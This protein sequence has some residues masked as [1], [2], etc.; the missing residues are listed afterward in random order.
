MPQRNTRRSRTFWGKKKNKTQKGK[1][2]LL[3]YQRYLVEKKTK[4]GPPWQD[5]HGAC[6]RCWSRSHGRVVCL[7][8]THLMLP[9]QR[10]RGTA[11][12]LWAPCKRRIPMPASHCFKPCHT[13]TQKA[14]ALP[15]SPPQECYQ[16]W[17]ACVSSKPS[18]TAQW[19]VPLIVGLVF[20]CAAFALAVRGLEGRSRTSAHRRTPQTE[21]SG[22][23]SASIG[24]TIAR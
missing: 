22:G 3:W 7:R 2:N 14:P 18:S 10:S 19:V 9:T 17:E 13:T 5:R 20:A 12:S 11:W 23:S 8:S 15:P 24:L 4:K 21:R 1:W 6:S 16:W